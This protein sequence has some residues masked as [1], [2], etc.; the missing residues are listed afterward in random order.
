MPQAQAEQSALEVAA[1]LL[2]DADRVLVCQRSERG[3]H[4]GRWEFP[5]GKLEAG[6][7]AR[8]CLVR[9]L[10]EE[11]SIDAEIGDLLQV[12][13]FEYPAGPRVR[14]QFFAV[15]AWRGA[16]ENRVFARIVWQPLSR[17]LELDFLQADLPLVARL[18]GQRG[19]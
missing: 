6:E 14:I 7:T 5:G 16:I 9:E 19:G 3:A 1:G 10:K 13:D 12:V 11:L 17:L 4:P 18:A 2:R 8:A 15:P